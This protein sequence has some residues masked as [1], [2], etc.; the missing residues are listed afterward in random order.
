MST[1]QQ[2]IKS[3]QS[4]KISTTKFWYNIACAVST[5]V[6]CWYAWH[7]KLDWEMFMVYLGSV[8][9][10]ASYSKYVMSRYNRQQQSEPTLDARQLYGD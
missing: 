4:D 1:V 6:V 2:L 9:G 8:G 10:F 5:G 7:L 3:N